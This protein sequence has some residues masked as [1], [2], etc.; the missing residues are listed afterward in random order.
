MNTQPPDIRHST[1]PLDLHHRGLA[2][3]CS[4]D[5]ILH[6]RI[7]INH[8]TGSN[9]NPLEMLRHGW[10][11]RVH[12]L[13]L[14]T[15][16]TSYH[17]KITTAP[18]LYHFSHQQHTELLSVVIRIHRCSKKK[19]KS[20]RGQFLVIQQKE[21]KHV[22]FRRVRMGEKVPDSGHKTLACIRFLRNGFPPS[23]LP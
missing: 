10:L 16:L 5:S 14:K 21:Q 23:S 15:S 7:T 22:S 12:D 18:T 17:S 2:I 3:N 6:D 8:S 11:H 20:I 13:P 19:D 9:S 4:L 1:S